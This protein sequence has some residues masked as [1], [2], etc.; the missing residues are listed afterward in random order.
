MPKATV[1][2]TPAQ[3][4]TLSLGKASTPPAPEAQRAVPPKDAGLPEARPKD[5][6]L[7]APK[8]AKP[9][10]NPH[11]LQQQWLNK[12]KGREVTIELVSGRLLDGVVKSFDTYT[13]LLEVEGHERLVFKHSIATI[14]AGRE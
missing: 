8:P 10:T 14:G 3:R 6:G 2:W 5:E 4:T 7:S 1:Q 9:P 12:A 13:L 11:W